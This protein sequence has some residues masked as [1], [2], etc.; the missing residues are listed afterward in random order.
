MI[1]V[2]GLWLNL[3]QTTEEEEVIKKLSMGLWV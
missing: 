2:K 1:V 3:E